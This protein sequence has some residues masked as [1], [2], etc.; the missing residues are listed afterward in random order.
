MHTILNFVAGRHVSPTSNAWFD[1]VNP[2]TGEPIAQVPDSDQRDVEAAVRAA[3]VAFPTW[4]WAPVAERSN[5]LLDLARRIE[6][7][8]EEL[9][10]AE[11]A[12]T[13]KPLRLSRTVDIP[14]AAA[15]FRF[16]ATAVLHFHS[17]IGRA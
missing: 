6:E 9:A 1:K 15:N 16:F 11:T 8:Q 3:A 10:L 5:L 13:G 7:R 4:S 17:E 12:D 14:R 2:A